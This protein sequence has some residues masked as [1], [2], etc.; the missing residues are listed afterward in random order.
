MA[1]QRSIAEDGIAA[2][3][4]QG[5]AKQQRLELLGL[6]SNSFGRAGSVA[7]VPALSA[8]PSLTELGLGNASLDASTLDTSTFLPSLKKLTSI[9]LAS[10]DAA[11][12]LIGSGRSSARRSSRRRRG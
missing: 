1:P 3:L 10:A 11:L 2:L 7:L 8:L 6:S 5:L 12:P 9:N 4:S